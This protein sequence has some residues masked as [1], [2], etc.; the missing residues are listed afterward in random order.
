[1]DRFR[2]L[3]GLLTG[4]RALLSLG[5]ATCK[6]R[7]STSYPRIL[8]VKAKIRKGDASIIKRNNQKVFN[9]LE[10][11]LSFVISQNGSYFKIYQNSKI[12]GFKAL[13]CL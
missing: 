5:R 12:E 11:R 1:M 13:N 6:I 7:H 3:H 10:N 8:E 2:G 9:N 4:H